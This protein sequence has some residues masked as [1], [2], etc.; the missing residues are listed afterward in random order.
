MRIRFQCDASSNYDEMYI[1]HIYINATGGDDRIEYDF[2]LIDKLIEEALIYKAVEEYRD[3]IADYLIGYLT[4]LYVEKLCYGGI[5]IF[6]ISRKWL[7]I[8]HSI[9]HS[10]N[11]PAGCKGFLWQ[12][13]GTRRICRHG[14]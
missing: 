2:D 5:D 13:E 12:G 10:L 6:T 3:N 9:F 14:V 11:L 4:T 1:D 7:K 8:G